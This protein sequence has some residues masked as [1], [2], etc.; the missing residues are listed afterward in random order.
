[1]CSQRGSDRDLS[2]NCL[3]HAT[4]DALIEKKEDENGLEDEDGG[5]T[6]EFSGCAAVQSRINH[7]NLPL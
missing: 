6:H 1:M 5:N 2:L 4:D 3:P 7:S